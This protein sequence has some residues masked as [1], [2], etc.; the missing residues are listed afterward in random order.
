MF[1]SGTHIIRLI[2]PSLEYADEI[3]A[4]RAEILESDADSEDRFG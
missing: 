2:E 3:W 4:F 1:E